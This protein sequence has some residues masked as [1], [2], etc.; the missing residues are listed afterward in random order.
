[1]VL[2]CALGSGVPARAEDPDNLHYSTFS[3]C[4]IDPATGEV[5]VAVTTRVP[6]V[7]RAVP[8]VEAGVGGVATQ[9]WTVVEYG[10]QGLALLKEGVA[11]EDVLKR[12]LAD[13]EGR[14]RR[15]V[16]VIDMQGRA[17]AFT[18]AE[19]GAWAGHRQGKNY[20]VQANIMVGPEVIE[21]VAA[22]FEKTE[23]TGMPLAERMILS[24]EAG[25]A[26]G[27]DKRWGLFQS[28]AIKVADPNHPG[29]GGDHI[30]LAIEVG[31][32][33]QPVAEMKRIYYKTAGRLGWR[34]FSEV[35]GAD[36]IELK[37]MLHKLGHWRPE[38]HEF[39]T[40]PAF[41]ADATLQRANPAEYDR[42][43]GEYRKAAREYQDTYA[44]FDAECLAAVDAFR[45]TQGMDYEGTA[46]GL[47]DARLVQR[48]RELFYFGK[49]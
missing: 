26:T 8:W 45:K 28:A 15:Q 31:E 49:E 30:S 35:R 14:E 27:G 32:H 9:S 4:A 40:M 43:V 20:T 1:M 46:R 48:L 29:R 36:V 6:F 19:C 22:Y 12:M 23:G 3:L 47:V 39:P 25:Q 11:P 16:G 2:L 18:G 5:G 17:A 21:A 33:Q 7:G 44:V 34:E 38:L 13:D 37:R 10:R 41:N 24:L 42:L